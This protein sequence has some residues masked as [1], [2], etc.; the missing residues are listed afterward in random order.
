VYAP[1]Q[2]A[3]QAP[4][5]QHVDLMG[6]HHLEVQH[7][8]LMGLCHLEVPQEPPEPAYAATPVPVAPPANVLPT[9]TGTA[10]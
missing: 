3:A 5:V 4:H 10:R 7:V 2:V 1:E 6:L 9:A 8:D